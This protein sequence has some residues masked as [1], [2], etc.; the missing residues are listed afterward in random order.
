LRAATTL[1]AR[2]IC[3]DSPDGLRFNPPL[4]LGWRIALRDPPDELCRKAS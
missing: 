3:I 2:T 4:V 1:V